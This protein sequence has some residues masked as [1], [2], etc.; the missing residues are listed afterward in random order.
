[1]S[2]NTGD[3]FVPRTDYAICKPFGGFHRFM[4]SYGLK[5][6]DDDD[7]AEAK[8]ILEGMRD[9]DRY[10]WEEAQREKAAAGR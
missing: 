8:R 10:E 4:Q 3:V 5:P 9:A 6:W 7:I 2:A 1:M